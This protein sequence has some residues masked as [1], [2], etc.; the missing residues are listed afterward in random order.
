MER[1]HASVRVDQDGRTDPRTT[2]RLLGRHQRK[3][4]TF[5]GTSAFQDARLLNAGP[6]QAIFQGPSGVKYHTI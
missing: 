1:D 4:L 5:H 6:G 3:R 2:G